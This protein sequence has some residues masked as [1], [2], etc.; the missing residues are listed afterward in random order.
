MV[1]SDLVEVGVDSF[2]EGDVFI[3]SELLILKISQIGSRT[4]ISFITGASIRLLDT[5]L[6]CVANVSAVAIAIIC[7]V[8]LYREGWYSSTSLLSLGQR[9]SVA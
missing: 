5:V 3:E 2:D 4:H 6:A 9:T 7:G 8:D 1:E